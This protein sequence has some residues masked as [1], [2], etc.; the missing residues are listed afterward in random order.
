[1]SDGSYIRGGGGVRLNPAKVGW[2][3]A[4]LALV[5]L[6][7]STVVL[8]WS[9]ASNDARASRLRARGVP[10][11]ATVTS[12][13]GISSGIGMAVEYY[14]CRGRYTLAGTTQES[15]IRGSRREL[16]PGR[17]VAAVAVPGEP[18]SLSLPGYGVSPSVGSYVPG[19]VVGSVTLVV[20]AAGVAVRRPSRLRRPA[21]PVL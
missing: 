10:V 20:A 8:L 5:G 9:A 12:C 18:A 2:A 19:I 3:L 4:A 21:K 11:E 13:A 14:E 15:V 17:S 6:I 1:M 7:V 16:S